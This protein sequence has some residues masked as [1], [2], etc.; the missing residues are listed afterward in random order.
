MSAEGALTV[1]RHGGLD[2]VAALAGDW[3]ELLSTSDQDPL[4][5]GPR[6]QLSHAR[7]F[8][9]P[10]DCFAYTF[11]DGDALIGLATF[12]HEPRRSRFALRRVQW[13]GDGSFD[14]DYQEA[15]HRPGEEARVARALLDA[16]S[17]E[18]GADAVVLAMVPI[19]APFRTSLAQELER[20][21]LARRAD[22]LAA[23]AMDLPG[24]FDD[25]VG[26]LKKRMRSKVRQALRRA[27]AAEVQWYA[28]GTDLEPWLEEL[29]TLHTRRW[30]AIGEAGSFADER[31]RSWYR[32]LLPLES[33]AGTLA[34]ARLVNE[35]RTVA[36]QY[37]L[38]RGETYYQ[39]QEGYEPALESERPGSQLRAAMLRDLIERGVR[40]YDF[41]EGLTRH[42]TDWGAREVACETFSFPLPKLMPRA[43]F[44][45]K[46]A[47]Q[48][49][50]GAA[51]AKS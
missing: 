5:N 2:A 3:E 38:V 6:W 41:M 42:K 1:E 30:N 40:R 45:L 47:L 10:S 18:R 22:D 36:V 33:A 25:Y 34:L 27:D 11:R 35:G 31:R 51:A 24:S 43:V 20:R 48:R 46:N 14:T 37:G 44:A 12:K 32:D 8:A 28:P 19:D 7:A 50:R 21:G 26:G 23:G 17:R 39:V 16:L 29:W 13:L 15:V 9:R 4:C 49:E